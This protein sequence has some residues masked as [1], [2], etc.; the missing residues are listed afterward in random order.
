METLKEEQNWK[1]L[2]KVSLERRSAV[3]V[4][5]NDLRKMS[6]GSEG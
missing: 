2:K 1:Y 5:R 3:D 6:E 4:V